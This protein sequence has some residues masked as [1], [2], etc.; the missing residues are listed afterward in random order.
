VIP[1]KLH[2]VYVSSLAEGGLDFSF[3]YWA[4]VRSAITSNP[5]Y[6]AHLW[7]EHEPAS[8]Y[9]D[10]LKGEIVLH[11]IKAPD[12]IFGNPVPHYA[13][14]ADIVR[15]QVLLNEGG[16]YLDLDTL[17]VR[18]FDPL[19]KHK[20]VMSVVKNNGCIFGLGNAVIMAAP[21][22]AFMT[23][24][25]DSYRTFRSKGHDEYY[26]EHGAG[27]SIR[28]AQEHPAEITILDEKAFLTPDM[29]PQ[30]LAAL[31]LTDEEYPEAFCHHLWGK[32]AHDVIDAMNEHNYLMYPGLYSRV[33]GQRLAG[34]IQRLRQPDATLADSIPVIP[35]NAEI[36]VASVHEMQVRLSD[37]V[38]G[39]KEGFQGRGI[40]MSVWDGDIANAWILLSELKRLK[41]ELPVEIWTPNGELQPQYRKLLSDVHPRVRFHELPDPVTKYAIKPYAVYRSSFAQVLWLDNDCFPLRDPTFLFDDDGFRT[42]GSLFWR[43]VSGA[44]RSHYWHVDAAIWKLYGIPY[45]DCEEFEVGQFLVDKDKCLA[46]LLFTMFTNRNGHVY[47]RF[48]EER[49][50]EKDT[51]RLAWQYFQ[52]RRS[53]Q[54]KSFGYLAD[55]EYSAFAF[56]PYGPLHLGLPNPWHKWGGGSV[57]VQ[58]DRQGKPLFNHRNLYK[59][60]LGQTPV[61]QPDIENEAIYHVHFSHLQE[62]VADSQSP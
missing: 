5:G 4:A 43:D 27:Q 10:D 14:K 21:S 49:I 45:C 25:F 52:F 39:R 59:F 48:C 44:D 53:G 13:H 29:T 57:M 36:S 40:V 24:W 51:Y 58:R 30:G 37:F 56:M 23:R 42:K 8:R 7:Y 22:S 55:P 16:I 38:N 32:N 15:L 11:Q 46:E 20:V 3:C 34:D 2:F 50:A 54:L 47:Y 61:H 26:D 19:L 35:R 18:C 28:L 31:F 9:W 12:A 62:A 60:V 33:L 41:V 17:T 6:E 1:R